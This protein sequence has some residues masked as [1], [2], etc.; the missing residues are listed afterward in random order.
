MFFTNSALAAP[1]APPLPQIVDRA[2]KIVSTPTSN[3]VAA[4]KML[5]SPSVNFYF[6]GELIAQ[7]RD[8]WLKF[9]VDPGS[10][11]VFVMSLATGNPI[12]AVEQVSGI[13]PPGLVGQTSTIHDCCKWA[14]IA[15]FHLSSNGEVDEVRLV[16]GQTDWTQPVRPSQVH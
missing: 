16:D 13:E 11:H 8:Q 12:I 1:L 14:R 15:S 5:F 6:N 4:Y 7:T 9:A 10:P 3:D 2:S